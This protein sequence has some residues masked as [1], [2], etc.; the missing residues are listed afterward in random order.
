MSIADTL[1]GLIFKKPANSAEP[2]DPRRSRAT[3]PPRTAGTA[4]TGAGATS[5]TEVGAA[6]PP[7]RSSVSWTVSQ[8]KS[9]RQPSGRLPRWRPMLATA[10]TSSAAAGLG[11]RRRTG[12]RR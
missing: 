2:R 7:L 3:G 11:A 12:A 5:G 6:P 1:K 9:T 10:A 4:A 8:K